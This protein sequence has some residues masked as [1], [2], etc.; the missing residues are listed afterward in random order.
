LYVAL[1]LGYLDLADFEAVKVKAEN[2]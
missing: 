2:L 1:E